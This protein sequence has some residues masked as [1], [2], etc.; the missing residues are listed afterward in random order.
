MKS[1]C[2]S[3]IYRHNRRLILAVLLSFGIIAIAVPTAYSFNLPNENTRTVTGSQGLA[4]SLS[5]ANI[6]VPSSISSFVSVEVTVQSKF[7]FTN[8]SVY[9]VSSGDILQNSTF[10]Y[11]LTNFAVAYVH[12]PANLIKRNGTLEIRAQDAGSA[13][14]PL[15]WPSSGNGFL[16]SLSLYAGI[17]CIV[18]AIAISKIHARSIWPVFP[19]FVALSVLY[20]Q[21]YDDFFL[22]SPGFRLISGVDPYRPSSS[23]LPGLTWAYPPMYL[24]WSYLIDRLY[25]VLPAVVPI[26]N[27][28]LN[29]LGTEYGNPYGAWKAL[30]GSNTLLL[31]GLL[32]LPLVL[33]FF[34]I[35]NILKRFTGKM[36][37]KLWLLNPFIIVVAVMWGQLDVLA[38]AFMLQA[39]LFSKNGK[40]WMAV[41]SAS[42]G[43]A[44]KVFPGLI[45]P[46]LLISSKNKARDLTAVLPVLAVT[47]L[48]YQFTGGIFSSIYGLIYARAIPTY[49]GIFVSNGLSWQVLLT[50]FGVS[51]FPPLFLWVFTPAF[52][53]ITGICS[54][55]KVPLPEYT[56]VI[57]LVFFL[58][59]NFVNPQYLLWLI[60]L[61]LMIDKEMYALFTSAIGSIFMVLTYSYTYFLNPAISWNY[62]SSV[63]GQVE[64][65]K[66]LLLGSGLIRV[67]IAMAATAMFSYM[68]LKIWKKA[69]PTGIHAAES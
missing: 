32:K 27:S 16:Q 42:M 68:L 54:W 2:I 14:I 6:S 47:L 25:L 60:P 26:L 8:M 35:F 18:V 15:S 53:V 62:Q 37:W 20:G 10:H 24:L 44:I 9:V 50:Y 43:A 21:R 17:I 4:V 46:Y 59:Y 34:W 40:T 65:I 1:G 63:L 61:L 51:S 30:L 41:F 5:P 11:K 57:L 31:Y 69:M 55:K 13:I 49:A 36:H 64:N 58:T 23:L 28:S 33:S 7:A 22:I 48:M 52:F 19:V 12:V 38:A 67:A 56:A 29:Y 3:L 45:I 39:I 66:V